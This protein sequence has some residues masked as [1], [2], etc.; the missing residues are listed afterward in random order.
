MEYAE[1]EYSIEAGIAKGRP[2]PDWFIDEPSL[3]PGDDFYI[4]GFHNL[5]T[6]RTIG[7]A[8]GP[9]PWT[10]I[11]TYAISSILNEDLI[12]PFIQIIREMDSGYLKYQAKIL[13]KSDN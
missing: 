4:R 3:Y 9:I 8:M 10:A 5:N 1:K 11:Y 7:M 13:E 12:D 6:C 2:L